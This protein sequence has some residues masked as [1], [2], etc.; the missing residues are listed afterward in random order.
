MNSWLPT[1]CKFCKILLIKVF[2]CCT[3]TG[4]AKKEAK[5]KAPFLTS[6]KE[7]LK[8]CIFRTF[9]P[10][11]FIISSRFYEIQKAV[12]TVCKPVVRGPMNLS[13]FFLIFEMF[14]KKKMGRAINEF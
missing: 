7:G 6:I 5:C 3:H 8:C 4:N 2:G 13:E 9:Q 10:F 12:I 1:P 11:F 14:I